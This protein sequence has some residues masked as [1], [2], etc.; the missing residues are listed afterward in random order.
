M[1]RSRWYMPD[2]LLGCIEAGGTKFV[3]A[4]ARGGVLLG[5]R[6]RIE[7][8]DPDTTLSA[9]VAWLEG[10]Q[11][12]HGRIEAI[13]I[14]SFGPIERNRSSPRWGMILDTPK[15]GWSGT[16]LATEI[17]GRFGVPVGFDTDV[18]GAAMAEAALGKQPGLVVY[19]TV[20]TGIGGG[21]VSSGIPI[22]GMR[23]A[24]MGHLYPP[25]HPRDLE[26]AGCCPFHG[27][28]LEGLASGPAIIAR[29]GRPLSELP[30]EHEAHGIIAFYLAHLS[31]TLLAALSPHRIAFGGGV[32]MTP[33]LIDAIRREAQA[34]NAGYLVEGAR[35]AEIIAPTSLNQDAGL[36]GAML[37][38]DRALQG[39]GVAR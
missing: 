32:M 29:W 2:P 24:E 5:D 14:A 12:R 38:A 26:F 17:G 27:P 20:G 23:H 30:P 10:A 9:V 31:I 39:G 19:V 33:G 34:L 8:T 16:P 7:T 15:S 28:C 36:Y 25:R 6:A 21:V 13:G 11:A 35:I 3:C 4:L 18:N 22:D 37:L 1:S